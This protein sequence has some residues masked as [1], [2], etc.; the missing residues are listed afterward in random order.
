MDIK[1]DIDLKC[2]K[3]LVYTPKIKKVVEFQKAM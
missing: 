1:L 2:Q 3:E